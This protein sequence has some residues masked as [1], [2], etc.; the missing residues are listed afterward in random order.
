MG[1][2]YQRF[3]MEYMTFHYLY[4]I[5]LWIT[6]PSFL[7]LGYFKLREEMRNRQTKKSN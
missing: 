1:F 5:G 6:C 2:D 3:Q 7:I 4:V